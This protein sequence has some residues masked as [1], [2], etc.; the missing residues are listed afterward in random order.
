[1]WKARPPT[2]LK[3]EVISRMP[4]SVL[5]SRL[6]TVYHELHHQSPKIRNAHLSR[7]PKLRVLHDEIAKSVGREGDV[8]HFMGSEFNVL[9]EGDAARIRPFSL[10]LTV[11]FVPFLSCAVTVRR[12][13]SLAGEFSFDTTVG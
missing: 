8:F 9:L 5:E 2:E 1:M 4:N 6:C 13:T 10:P 11:W 7:P 3:S 12:A